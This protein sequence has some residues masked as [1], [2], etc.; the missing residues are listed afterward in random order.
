MI[1]C[2]QALRHL[3]NYL[4]GTVDTADRDQVEAHLVRC[5]RCCGELN[6]A[7][8]LRRLLADCRFQDLPDD[9]HHR[10]NQTLDDLGR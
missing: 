6:F 8:E 3:W 10:L 1:D 7:V 5:V 9:V 2:Y 4:D